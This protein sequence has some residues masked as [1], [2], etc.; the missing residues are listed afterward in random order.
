MKRQIAYSLTLAESCFHL[1]LKCHT[2]LE[3][4]ITERTVKWVWMSKETEAITGDFRK[5]DHSGIR[6]QPAVSHGGETIYFGSDDY[7]VYALDACTG[8]EKWSICPS[9]DNG[10]S[11]GHWVQNTP[12]I[13]PDGETIYLGDSHHH[14]FALYSSN[15]TIKWR[16]NFGT[17]VYES[18][19]RG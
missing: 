14:G 1:A 16:Y 13:S 7:H 11:V 18:C 6:G 15:G 12:A 8:A 4:S 2:W 3:L 17:T 19:V 5:S 9:C 10:A